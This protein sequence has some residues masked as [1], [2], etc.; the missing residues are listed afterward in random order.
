MKEE[1]RCILIVSGL[2]EVTSLQVLVMVLMW[3]RGEKYELWKSKEK[4]L[5]LD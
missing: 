2:R 5:G 1:K 4:P 3:N